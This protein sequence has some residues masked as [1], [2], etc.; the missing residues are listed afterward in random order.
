[1]TNGRIEMRFHRRECA[2]QNSYLMTNLVFV[3]FETSVSVKFFKSEKAAFLLGHDPRP[4]SL[5]DNDFE[6]VYL[7]LCGRRGAGGL[8]MLPVL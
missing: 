8:A 5:L 7:P 1:M 3:P 2:D 4:S 6:A